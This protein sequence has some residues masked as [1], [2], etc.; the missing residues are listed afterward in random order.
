MKAW[1]RGQPAPIQ[2]ALRVHGLNAVNAEAVAADHERSAATVRRRFD[3]I[4]R[5]LV[6]EINALPDATWDAP[7][8]TRSRRSLGHVVGGIVGGPAGPFSHASSHLPYLRDYVES[9]T[10]PGPED[11]AGPGT[12]GPGG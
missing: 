4:H 12:P 5:R 1:Q 6:A 7:P 9:V 3:D 2:R 11:R 8:T 10:D